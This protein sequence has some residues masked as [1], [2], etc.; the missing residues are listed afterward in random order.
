M[1][2]NN[3]HTERY[4][5]HAPYKKLGLKLRYFYYNAHRQQGKIF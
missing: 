2:A 3:S 4:H 1:F 5:H